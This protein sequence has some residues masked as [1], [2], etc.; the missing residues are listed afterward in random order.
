M[1]IRA[2]SAHRESYG[3]ARFCNPFG[4]TS[5]G[6]PAVLVEQATKA[7]TALHR[8]GPHP[9]LVGR[10]GGPPLPEPLVRPGLVVVLDALDQ[11]PLQLPPTEDQQV[12]EDLAPGCPHPALRE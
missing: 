10:L 6:G 5:S 7:V 4:V 11:H 12:V 8:T 2:S 9:D 1:C 3:H